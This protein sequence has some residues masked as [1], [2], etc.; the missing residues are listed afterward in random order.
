MAVT[1]RAATSTTVT[2]P[3][4]AISVT[5]L[6]SILGTCAAAGS[7]QKKKQRAQSTRR[8]FI[9]H[10]ETL[11]GISVLRVSGRSR[12]AWRGTIAQ[13]ASRTETPPERSMLVPAKGS[14]THPLD[15]Q[16]RPIVNRH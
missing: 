10:L 14:E 15:R 12:V 8:I 5:I 13:P 7:I 9:A 1:Y 6:G 11:P 4:A 16:Q 2:F 3:S